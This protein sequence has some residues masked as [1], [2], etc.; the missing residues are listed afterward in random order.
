[1]YSF[2]VLCFKLFFGYYP[3]SCSE[4]NLERL[5]KNGD[6]MESFIFAPEQMEDLGN[7]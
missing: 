6:Y 4:E 7:S 5:L 2:G 3:L 1:M